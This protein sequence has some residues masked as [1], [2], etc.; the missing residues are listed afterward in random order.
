MKN[1]FVPEHLILFNAI[2]S[3]NYFKIEFYSKFFDRN[4]GYTQSR[5]DFNEKNDFELN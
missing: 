5:N 2:K 1:I 3:Y 4:N